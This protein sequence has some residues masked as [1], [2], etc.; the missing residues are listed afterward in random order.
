MAQL[1]PANAWAEILD[2]LPQ[3]VLILREDWT[4]SYWNHCLE[5]W[6]GISKSE[7]LGQPIGHL[8]PH[9][10]T[11]K[12]ITRLEPL[13]QGGPP[14]TFASQFHG[15]FL[16]CAYPNGQPRIQHTTAKSIWNE[17][18]QSWHALIIIHDVT[19]LARQVQAS[20]LLRK[21]ANEEMAE[22]KKQAT[23]LSAIQHIE[24]TYID[25]SNLH[26]T[27]D[28]ALSHLLHIT[29]S[30]YGFIGEVR[31]RDGLPYL[32][33]QAITN[34]AWNQETRD[35][36]DRLAP[37]FEFFNLATLFGQVL[38][39]GAYVIANDPATD[40]RRGGLP[41]GHPPLTAF[42]GLPIYHG[43]CF[44]GMAG[45]ANR[46]SGY[47]STLVED[48]Q[49]LMASLGRIFQSLKTE[50][51][52]TAAQQAL[53]ESET[54]LE[55][56]VNGTNEGL[57][58]WMD[59]SGEDMWWSP[60]FYS[61]LGYAPQDLPSNLPTFR[62]LLHPDDRQPV[63][64]A[65]WDHIHH[66]T[67]FDRHFR[68]CTQS[69]T[70]RWFH[71]QGSAIRDSDHRAIRM[72]G[73]IRDVTEQREREE[74]LHT[75]SNR[76]ILATSVAKMG[77]WDWD[78]PTNHLKWDTQMFE[79]FGVNPKD[80]S[81]T[82]DTWSRTLHP[83]D[84]SAAENAV[85]RALQG[86]EELNTKFR[87][88]WPDQSVHIIAAR[89]LVYWND[90]GHPMRMLG[91]NWD[92]TEETKADHRLR[93]SEQRFR[94]LADSA[95][96]LIW[97]TGPDHQLSW[98]NKPWL[99]FTGQ[100]LGQE[101]GKG[102]LQG[103]HPDDHNRY[104][105]TYLSAYEAKRSF[106]VEYRLR[107]I[108]KEFRWILS[109]GVPRFSPDG[110]FLGYIGSG[111]DITERK[112]AEEKF[113]LVVEAAPSGMIM[114]NQKGR[115]VLANQLVTQLFHYSSKELLGQPIELLIPER[116]RRTHEADVS[117]FFAH[118]ESR[119]MGNGRDLY[120]R[121]KDGTEFP[122]EVGL[123]PLK[124]GNDTYV[125]AS[126]VDI[127]KRKQW[128]EQLAEQNRMLALDA[129]IGKIISQQQDL[130][131]LLQKCAQAMVDHL[132][133]VNACIWLHRPEHHML[134]LQ[135]SSGDAIDLESLPGQIP[136][137]QLLIGHIAQEQKP[138]CTNAVPE[139]PQISKQAWAKQEEVVAFAG[140]P[141]LKDQE[142]M[143]VMALFA[144]SPFSELTLNTLRMIS[145]HI[146]MAIEGYQ[147][148]QAHQELSRQNE[149]ILA[150][151]GEG[152]FGLDLEGRATFMNPAA[153][154]L[155][156]YEPEELIGRPVHDVIHH[157]KPDGA[158]YP[159]D[160]CPMSAAFRNGIGR[161]IEA[162]VLWRKD[163]TPMP[164]EYTS[165]PLHDEKYEVRGAVITF[166]DITERKR[167]ED[168]FR[169]V[170]ETT[171]SGMVMTDQSGTIVLVNRLVETLFGYSRQELIGQPIEILLPA[172]FRQAH[173]HHRSG[174]SNKH[175]PHPKMGKGRELHGLHKDGREIPLEVGLNPI[176]TRD[177][178]FILSS[179]VDITERK[180][181]EQKRL[182]D[183][184]ALEQTNKE[185]VL[186]RDQALLAA[187][188]KAEF[189]ATMSHEIRTPLNGVIG[190]TSL[191]LDTSLDEDQRDMV[192]TVQHSGEFLLGI[193]NDI[194]DFSKIEAGKLNL[195]SLDFDIRVAIDE[196][197]GLLAERA[198]SKGLEL[199]SLVDASIPLVINGDPGRIRQILLNLIGN[200]IKFTNSGSVSVHVSATPNPEGGLTL[201]FSVADTGIGLSHEAQ[202]TLFQS[203]TQADSSTTRKYGGTGLGLAISKRLVTLMQGEIGL[204]SQ[205]GQ[206]SRFWFTLPVASSEA[207]YQ[208]PAPCPSLEGRR[209]AI[210]AGPQSIQTLLRHYAEMWGMH[211][212]TADTPSAGLTLLQQAQQALHPF[213][214]VI[215]YHPTSAIQDSQGLTLGTAIRQDPRLASLPLILLAEL[216]KRGEAKLAKD[217]GFAAYLT[218]PVRYQQWQACLKMVLNQDSP[219]SNSSVPLIT[220]HTL[221]E[222][223]AQSR[224]HI[225]LVEDNDVNQKV[226]VRML[227]KMGYRIDL[228]LNGQEAIQA[229][230]T[231]RYDL[232]LMDCQMPEMDGF[233]ATQKIREGE[234]VNNEG[235]EETSDASSTESPPTP[236]SSLHGP[237]R[238]RVP[239]LALTAN[240]L[241]SDRERCL[242]AGMDDFLTKPVRF[243]HLKA[244]LELWLTPTAEQ[245]DAHDASHSR[246]SLAS[247]SEKTAS[248]PQAPIDEQTL[249]E[250]R[251]LAGEDDPDF[252]ESLI[253]QFLDDL[254]RHL[255]NILR[256]IQQ[257]D[258]SSL[259]KAAHTCK[260]S[261]RYVG[262]FAL[263]D[264]CAQLETCS[265][266]QDLSTAEQHLSNLRA[267]IHRVTHTLQSLRSRTPN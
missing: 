79:L 218:Q 265:R 21:K 144:K 190:L 229:S 81:N 126:I 232:I 248:A 103:L 226:A 245:I 128:E 216:G 118:L 266:N 58:D 217:S 90:Q 13:F 228:A 153:A 104:G 195:E 83:A 210:I 200:A 77:I 133:A 156:G 70:Y 241:E 24:S 180:A 231:T 108:H 124:S 182:Q 105:Q 163:G 142:M 109:T 43:T 178:R 12:Y 98:V 235:F 263:S 107:N 240:A 177:G 197:I 34:I 101:L 186:A 192:N 143:G 183:A 102:W 222:S 7:M 166:N 16:P 152:I 18:T 56:A 201:H 264:L 233:E 119:A 1:E 234:R 71:G 191:L 137:G 176:E 198:A 150:S 15:Q 28:V 227:K 261:S 257:Q 135:A 258:S 174:Y 130:Q 187:R 55:L 8:Y 19:N 89:G 86:Q 154:R 115:I 123:Q 9:L 48:L 32:K 171:P 38:K 194:L 236:D 66:Q 136:I 246:N 62:Q 159:K 64:Q 46:P 117:R 42:L 243:E 209:L 2:H 175:A 255:E 239:I 94:S 139:D 256:S 165:T 145:D 110:A 67:P 168:R 49:P 181:A 146:A 158:I 4:V 51:E 22:R 47:P 196:T 208:F 72:A 27:F 26:G 87:I 250:L 17:A 100:S 219:I 45:V 60:N 189:L 147:V 116:F 59:L 37:E 41:E 57:W 61:L 164:V 224:H 97:L 95:P 211:C 36:Y 132:R 203:F 155:L 204:E 185:L 220:R 78:I 25:T 5:E 169:L 138:H 88:V 206:G 149:R 114:I 214:V 75:L 213:D 247:P 74:E 84:R 129:E 162:E 202:R 242:K 170:V 10:T 80:S 215:V 173:P 253:D 122:V 92:I 127:T 69:G 157:T 39:T 99:D 113:R 23:L 230:Q 35:L 53:Q 207:P 167:A 151:A 140:Y 141:L 212:E 106:T 252:L 93:E 68:M 193:L 85:Q 161:H 65:L 120:G 73:S 259:T 199:Y 6:T 223:R 225:L 188:S 11:S 237:P 3:G 82:F 52:R 20:E 134:E 254:P 251:T 63:D 91:V 260:G 131:P 221:N 125:L 148:H 172:R 179:I 96:V 44:I 160:E 54:R 112:K 40:P 31:Y 121:R 50:Q 111:I 76:L 238:P 249:E 267:E 30:T 29:E 184:Q 205:L 244:K 14:T 33:T 262:A